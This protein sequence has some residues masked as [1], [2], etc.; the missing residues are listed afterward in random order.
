LGGG[1]GVRYRGDQ[2]APTIEAYVG[3][4]VEAVRDHLGPDKHVLVE[5]GRSLVAAATVT[6]YSVMTVKRD[7]ITHV[8]V[9][10][11]TSDNLEGVIGIVGF[12]AHVAD[13]LDGSE[14]C[15]LVGKH[16]DS[17]DVIVANARMAAPRIGDV[18]VVPATGAY[19]YAMANN[20]N[21]VPRP[22]VVVCRD[23][24]A[25][26]AVRRETLDDLFVRDLDLQRQMHGVTEGANVSR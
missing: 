22:P 12:E 2:D 9:D 18:V 1:L 11:G 13:R 3:A 17:G 19:G 4:L 26:V 21:C 23:G 5:P 6:L 20:Y 7:Y 10:G 14:E 15:V 25:R 8:A 16:C 24:E